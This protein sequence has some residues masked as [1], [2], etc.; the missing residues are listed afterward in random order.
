MN[1]HY[2]IKVAVTLT[3]FNTLSQKEVYAELQQIYWTDGIGNRISRSNLDGTGRTTILTNLNAPQAITIDLDNG[4]MYWTEVIANK[5]EEAAV[6][7]SMITMK[8]DGYLK[9]VEGITTVDEVLR[10]AQE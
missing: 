6:A 4:Q 3:L 2:F 7:N 5:I 8:Q 10:V 1:R 9:V